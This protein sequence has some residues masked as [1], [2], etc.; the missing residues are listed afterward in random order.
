MATTAIA[1]STANTAFQGDRI[2]IRDWQPVAPRAFVSYATEED[3]FAAAANRFRH[4]VALK[5]GWDGYAAGA[6]DPM[7]VAFATSML[8][9]L[10]RTTTPA[11]QIVPGV[12]GDLQIEWHEPTASI[13]LHVIAP[14]RVRAWKLDNVSGEESE[15]E[16]TTNFGKLVP[17]LQSIAGPVIAANAAA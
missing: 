7:T 10:C 9:Q 8:H 11:P 15:L 1:S 5:K 17:W 13:E 6:V 16:L 4:L 12:D 14:N 2:D 3:W